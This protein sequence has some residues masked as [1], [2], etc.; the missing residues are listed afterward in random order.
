MRSLCRSRLPV[1]CGYPKAQWGC[2]VGVSKDSKSRSQAPGGMEG[3]Y[4]EGNQLKL[5]GS[6]RPLERASLLLR[7]FC[8]LR[9]QAGSL[10]TTGGF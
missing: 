8:K 3:F 2:D 9:V 6:L 10:W 5:Q 1:S 7:G 4:S